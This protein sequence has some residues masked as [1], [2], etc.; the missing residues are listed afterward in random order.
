MSKGDFLAADIPD[1]NAPM[2]QF[3]KE[4]MRRMK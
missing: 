1:K 4:V 2:P 3:D